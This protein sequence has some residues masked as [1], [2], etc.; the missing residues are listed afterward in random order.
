L[1]HECARMKRMRTDNEKAA[2][3]KLILEAQ[4]GE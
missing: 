3:V 1:G 4:Q 2:V